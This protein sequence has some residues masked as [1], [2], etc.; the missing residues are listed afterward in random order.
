MEVE[1]SMTRMAVVRGRRWRRR[2]SEV[3]G[4]S[5]AVL[6]WGWWLGVMKRLRRKVGRREG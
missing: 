2:V 1:V 6:V 5:I 3:D 4:R